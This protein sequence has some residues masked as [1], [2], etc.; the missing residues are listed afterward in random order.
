[1]LDDQPSSFGRINVWLRAAI[2]LPISIINENTLAIG[3]NFMKDTPNYIKRN[4]I[5]SSILLLPFILA[6]ASNSIDRIFFGHT[7]YQSWLWSRAAILTWIVILP[8]LALALAISSYVTYLVT[9]HGR[10]K[11]SLIQ[12]LFDI[13]H[14][15]PVILTGVF[16][17]GV[18]FILLFH[19]SAHCWRQNPI[20]FFTQWHQTWQC[21]AKGFLGG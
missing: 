4:G 9:N 5:V 7:L 13:K 2:D 21:T 12:R 16:A 6:V 14:T 20:D 3:D 1:M 11:L 19:D 8:A 18:V 10:R 15:W 17:L